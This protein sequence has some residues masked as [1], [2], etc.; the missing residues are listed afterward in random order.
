MELKKEGPLL[1]VIESDL[2]KNVSTLHRE[3]GISCITI[4][5]TRKNY[6][7]PNNIVAGLFNRKFSITFEQSKPLI[8]HGCWL[9]LC[10]PI[11]LPFVL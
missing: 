3:Y 7:Q 8:V 4:A 5:P 10:I 2:L 1:N 9:R 11:I 6:G